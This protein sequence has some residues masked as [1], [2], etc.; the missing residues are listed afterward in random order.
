[1]CHESIPNEIAEIYGSFNKSEWDILRNKA[2]SLKPKFGYLGM[3]QMQEN[4]K[5]IELEAQSHENP[6][7]IKQ[8]IQ[9]IETYWNEASPEIEQ[10][11]ASK[12][13]N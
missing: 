9:T 1:M 10:L 2:H 3:N 7:Q 5:L 13:T 12:K 11:I 4:A 8:L 6:D